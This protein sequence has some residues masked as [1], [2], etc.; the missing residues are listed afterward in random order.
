[1]LEFRLHHIGFVVGNLV[2]AAQYFVQT[3]GYRIESDPIDDVLQ[4]AQVQFLHQPGATAW[5]EL[6][7][8]L[9]ENSKLHGALQRG[10]TLHHLCYEVDDVKA[11]LAHLRAQGCMPLG[12][13]V[14]GAAYD[15][16]PI[17]WAMD[18][19]K[20]LVELVE[21]GPGPRS[22]AILEEQRLGELS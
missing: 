9:G 12:N 2:E 21:S 7:T 16:R 17:A 4:T 3:L 8:P 19:L 22:L 13:P 1:M 11:G 10:T 5:L 20:G 14:P 6:V 18:G 15:D